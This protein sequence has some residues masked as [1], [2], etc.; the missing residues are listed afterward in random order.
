MIASPTDVPVPDLIKLSRADRKVE[1][2]SK[3]VVTEVVVLPVFGSVCVMQFCD[4][5]VKKIQIRKTKVKVNF[6]CRLGCYN[7]EYPNITS[8]LFR[9]NG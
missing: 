1:S 7:L 9:K 5:A 3:I 2:V 8:M 6:M 4:F